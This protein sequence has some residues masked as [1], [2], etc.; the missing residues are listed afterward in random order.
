MCVWYLDEKGVF[1]RARDAGAIGAC[2][3]ANGTASCL[4][5]GA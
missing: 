5:G 4:T 1:N 2:T 3:M